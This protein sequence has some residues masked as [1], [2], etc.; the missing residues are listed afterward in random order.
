MAFLPCPLFLLVLL[1]SLFSLSLAGAPPPP[2]LSLPPCSGKK[3]VDVILASKSKGLD[4][5][6]TQ[7]DA[8]A[9]G[10]LLLSCQKPV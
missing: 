8:Q 7:E 2:S 6:K 10:Q 1:R 5:I 4:V 9:L 3:L